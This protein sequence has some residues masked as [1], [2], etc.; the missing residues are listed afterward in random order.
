MDGTK[1]AKVQSVFVENFPIRTARFTADGSQ[2][3]MGA[4][5]PHFHF[6]DLA[7]GKVH[8]VAGIQG[9]SEKSLERF[10]VSPDGDTIAFYGDG[11]NAV[12]VSARSKMWIANVKVPGAVRSL[13]YA[14]EGDLLVGN[15]A[16]VVHRWDAR[17]RRCLYRFN[18]EGS[19]MV[20][21]LTCSPNSE[22]VAT[23]CVG[24]GGGGGGEGG[25]ACARA[26][27]LSLFVSWCT[28][29]LAWAG[30]CACVFM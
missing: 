24:G 27:P 8:R 28:A 17:T 3:I 22:L 9:R 15:D 18:D 26:C 4:R 10:V 5:R 23:G 2:V 30:S 19:T 6:F 12:L 16:G 13:A 11:G 25:G 20:T 21:A 29:G 1:N 7:S 14:P